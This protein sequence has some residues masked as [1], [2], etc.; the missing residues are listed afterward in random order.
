M[1]LVFLTSI[2]ILLCPGGTQSSDCERE[3]IHQTETIETLYRLQCN[4]RYVSLE[5]D[6]EEKLLLKYNLLIPVSEQLTL[7]TT[8]PTLA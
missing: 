5:L 8:R 4:L 3:V 6:L 2:L 1:M 7:S